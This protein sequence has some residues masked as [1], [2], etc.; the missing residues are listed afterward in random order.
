VVLERRLVRRQ[1][2][3]RFDPAL[4]LLHRLDGIGRNVESNAD[5]VDADHV[6]VQVE[7]RAAGIGI[8][9]VLGRFVSAQRPKR[10]TRPPLLF[11]ALLASRQINMRKVDGWQTLAAKPI[12]QQFDLAA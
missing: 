4:E 6:A 2:S 12:D 1:H 3:L 11:W 8:S 7:A 5:I 9:A 10:R